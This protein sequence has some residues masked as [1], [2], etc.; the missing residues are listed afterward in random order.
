MARLGITGRAATTY[1]VL[2]GFQRGISLL[3]LPFIARVMPP[4]EYGAASM[5]TAAATLLLAVLAGPI[6]TVV[7]RM[8]PQDDDESRGI[9]RL[10]GIYSYVLLPVFGAAVATVF[11][12]KVP[13]FLG[14]SGELWAIEIL[15]LVLQVSMTVFA[16]PMV[17]SAQDLPR[18]VWL[19]SISTVVY[20]LSKLVLVV[21][22]KMG[23]LG[24]VV[25]DLVSA[26]VSAVLAWTLVRVPRA[27]VSRR[28][29]NGLL[30]FALPLVPHKSAY[31]AITSLSRPALATVSTLAQVGLL[32]IGLNVAAVASL[33]IGEFN[34]AVQPRFSRET[35]PAPTQSTYAPIRWQLVLAVAVPAAIGAALALVG[36]WVFPAPYWPSFAVAGIL[37]LGQFAFGVYPIA[38]NYLVLTAGVPKYSAFA[39]GAG[40]VVILGSILVFGREYG[41]IGVAYATSAGYFVMTAVAFSMARL[42][43]LDIAWRAWISCWPEITIGTMALTFSAAALLFPVGSGSSRTLAGGSLASLIAVLALMAKR[44]R[45]VPEIAAG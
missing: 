1:L 10:A 37:L 35:F 6:D 41:A 40:A 26:A 7:F 5:L 24:W 32:A 18:F 11:A 39:S 14:I 42:A 3:I 34:R 13:A 45:A 8:V 27:Q 9:L 17:Q 25:S 20:A 28:H 22:L 2:A 23:V 31:W 33:V 19:A 36:K 4:A 29:L 43:K 12:L 38:I 30:S 21:V 15:A 44:Q 16:L